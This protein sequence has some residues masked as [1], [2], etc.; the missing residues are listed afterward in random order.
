M[1]VSKLQS[2]VLA[3]ALQVL[4]ISRVFIASAPA[5]GS[6]YAIVATWIAGT[7]ALLGGYDAVS[8]ASTISITP[9]SATN[10]VRYSGAVQYSGEHAGDAKSWQLVNNWN[11][12]QSGCNNV[13]EI[14]PGLWLTNS[15]TYLARVGGTPTASGTFNFTMQIHS[16]AN[17]GGGDSD[18]RSASIVIAAGTANTA[19]SLNPVSNQTTNVGGTVARTLV[20]ADADSPAQTLTFSLLTG[21]A[22][23]LV[24]INNTNALFSWRPSVTNANSTNLITV[25]VADSGSPSLS[26]T[27]SFKVI[28]N[29]LARPVVSS[30]ALI[31]GKFI[32]QVSGDAG[33]DY[34]VQVSTNMID[35]NI[36]STNNSPTMPFACTNPSTAPMQFYR[37]KAGPPLP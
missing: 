19:P 37:V 31:N 13:Y 20:A 18:T 24:Q 7:V 27:Q 23:S 30:A 22:N 25:K 33:P 28:V 16:S 10:G 26:T 15:S 5:A 36:V 35:W 3:A 32:L 21:P 29:P 2:L 14:A 34:A 8:G 4:P 9:T 17:C 11:G 12:A 6:S 1:R